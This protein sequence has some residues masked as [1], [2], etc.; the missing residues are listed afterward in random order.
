MVNPIKCLG[1]V[2]VYYI[3]LV[4]KWRLF[5]QKFSYFKQVATYSGSIGAR[6]DDDTISQ[7]KTKNDRLLLSFI[8]S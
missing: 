1:E 8:H 5:V 6:D 7:L 4:T 3:Y 2:K